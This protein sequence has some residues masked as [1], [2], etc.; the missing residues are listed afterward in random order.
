LFTNDWMAGTAS[1][2]PEARGAFSMLLC[3]QWDRG[4]LPNQQSVL[5]RLGTGSC[6][7]SRSKWTRIWT[8]LASK[9]RQGD[10]GL[11]RNPKLERVRAQMLKT[12]E[13]RAAAG[14]ARAERAARE[15]GKF[16]PAHAGDDQPANDQQYKPD[17]KYRGTSVQQAALVPDEVLRSVVGTAAGAENAPPRPSPAKARLQRERAS[18]GNYKAV[19]KLSHTVIDEKGELP[20]DE[21]EAEVKQRC[22]DTTIS[23]DSDLVA[24]AVASALCQRRFA[25]P[26]NGSAAGVRH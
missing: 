12:S 3:H 24:R 5:L 25:G 16:A 20:V 4:G 26:S 1:L 23:Y 13:K 8:E 21:L 19:L 17:P 11:L 9:F 22:A 6:P 15:H 14:K 7:V 2:S 18:D 10:D